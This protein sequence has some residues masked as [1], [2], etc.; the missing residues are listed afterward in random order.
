WEYVVDTSDP[1]YSDG[2]T[3]I[4]LTITDLSGK[5]IQKKI[6]FYFDNTAPI[7]M[8][9][10][11]QGY[12]TNLY[13]GII[14]VRGESADTFGIDEV[15]IRILD[16]VGVPLSSFDLA[17]GTN[18]WVFEFDSRLYA[19]PAGDIRLEARATDRAGNQ[20]TT[21]LHYDDVLFENSGASITI[22]DVLRIATGTPVEGTFITAAE[23]AAI[24]MDSIPISI[25]NDL[26][27]PSVTFVSPNNGQNIGGSI[28][29]TGTAYDDDGIDR[30]EMRLDLN[31]DGDY[32]DS[33]NIDGIPGTDGMFEVQAD[34]ETLPGT[35]LWTQDLNLDGELYQVEAGHD[36]RVAIQVRAIDINALVGN[37]LEIAVRFDD[38]IPRVES[39][40]HISGSY[41]SG[42]FTLEGN[43]LD[44]E[45]V[46]RVRLSYDGGISYD[47][48]FQRG[49]SNDG[50]ITE[51]AANDL[52]M[53]K[54]I[55][56]GNIPRMGALTSA[57]L[58]LRLLV[59]DNASYQALTY[60]T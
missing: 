43:I 49:V 27:K 60:I 41:V 52:T 58:Y 14:T 21:V 31:G 22:E 2:E 32:L 29:V 4:H 39:L 57:P 55:D 19:D 40:S 20:S 26:D 9:K 25:D 17:D 30:V 45:R 15:L 18:A 7:V 13:N 1:A 51:N 35:M 50:S 56:T 33:F 47:D 28:L 5:D 42:T 38:T 36:G 3:E 37:P 53:A 8:V 12:A 10:N 54:I 44:D 23:I 59:I 16:D 24:A 6:L 11:P 34:W 48:L 46:D